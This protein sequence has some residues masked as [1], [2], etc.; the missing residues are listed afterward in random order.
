MSS[1]L[2]NI[3]VIL[4]LLLVAGLG[5]YLYTQYGSSNLNNSEVQAQVSVQSSVFLA[6]LQELQQI[7]LDDSVFTNP[8]FQVLK[9]NSQPIVP[10]YVG[11]SNPFTTG[12]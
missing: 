11:R 1:T 7:K 2:Q 12:G 10:R 9:N 3:V 4:G 5:Y 6:R 8:Q